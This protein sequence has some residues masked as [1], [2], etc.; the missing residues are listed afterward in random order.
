MLD[1]DQTEFLYPKSKN[2]NPTTYEIDMEKLNQILNKKSTLHKSNEIVNDI[3]TKEELKNIEENFKFKEDHIYFKKYKLNDILKQFKPLFRSINSIFEMGAKKYGP[4]A[5]EK[6]MTEEA[7]STEVC[8]QDA[9]MRHLLMILTCSYT[10]YESKLRHIDH[11]A[12]RA[13]MMACQSLRYKY[14]NT[15]GTEKLIGINDLCILPNTELNYIPPL[16]FISLYKYEF[17][18]N[19]YIEDYSK[20]IENIDKNTDNFD[21]DL[22]LLTARYILSMMYDFIGKSDTVTDIYNE[23]TISEELFLN[24]GIII[25]KMKEKIGK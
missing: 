8:C 19:K 9:I 2:D 18:D 20:K 10:D 7:S 3:T 12:C 15:Y 23:L 4:Y 25:L 14:Q 22:E 13:L 5:W 16:I 21:T 24:I 6:Q 11:V 1:D 17:L